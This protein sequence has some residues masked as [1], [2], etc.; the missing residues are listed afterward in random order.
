MYFSNSAWGGSAQ[1]PGLQQMTTLGLS[2]APVLI[3]DRYSICPVGAKL[4]VESH[5]S[6]YTFLPDCSSA[7]PAAEGSG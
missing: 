7:L 2:E 4:F 1:P 5:D 6:K 3:H